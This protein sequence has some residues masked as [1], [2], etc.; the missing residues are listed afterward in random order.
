MRWDFTGPDHDLTGG[1][2]NADPAAIFGPSGINNLFNPGVLNGDMNPQI[3]QRPRPFNSWNVS[4]QPAFGVAWNPHGGD[5]WLGK[6]LGGDRTVIRAGFSLRRFTEPQQYF[7]NQAS[8]YGAFYFQS[9]FLNPIGSGN[10]GGFNPGGLTL[11]NA[12]PAFGVAPQQYLKTEPVS[13]FTFLGGP[14]GALAGVLSGVGGPVPYLCNL[15]GSSF[16]PCANNLGYTGAGAGY[17]IN[18]FQVNPFAQQVGPSQLVAKGY[19]NYN[20]LQVDFRQRS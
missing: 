17:P 11:G 5:G 20:A 13:D 18:N 6:L 16:G 12:L 4:P 15:V 2:H 19:S 7:W 14:A 3:A 9:F 10:Y 1:Y 8:D